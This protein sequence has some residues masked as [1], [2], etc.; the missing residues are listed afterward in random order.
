M[1]V[2]HAP[3]G[4]RGLWGSTMQMG[5]PAGLLVSSGAFALVSS[6]PDQAFLDWGWRL[7]FLASVVLLVVGIYIR[8]NITEPA[9]FKKLEDSGEISSAP[10]V[11]VFRHEKRK[12][13][14]MVFFQSIANVGYFLVSV[15][16]LT[17]V[18]D[19]LHLP[20]SWATTGLLIAAAVDLVTQPMFGAL[21]DRI[22]RKKVYAFG[23]IFFALYAFPFFYL[24]D[25]GNQYLIWLA[26]TLGL[27][28]GHAS[29]GSLHGV[30]YAEQYP[31][32]YR[33]SGSSI[34]YQLSGIVSSAPTP[35]IAAWLV[36]S[37]GS[38]QGVAW[39]IIAAAVIT[40]ICVFLVEETYRAPIDQ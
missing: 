13:F 9:A 3:P 6:L 17:Y 15:Y 36:N 19:V 7:P 35:L 40:L 39:Y 22:G 16:A 31:V 25:T 24:L 8:L 26:F 29:T 10:I 20:R 5:V 23:A 32:R 1:S 11:D 14:I 12:T 34:A 28:V 33:Y 21:S 38:S 27:G 18:V 2:E 30:I 4:K 37:T